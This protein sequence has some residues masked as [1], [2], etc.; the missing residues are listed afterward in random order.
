MAV[1]RRDHELGSGRISSSLPLQ[2][3]TRR[4]PGQLGGFS[5]GF[6]P[7]SCGFP[8]LLVVPVIEM[9][10]RGEE[11]QARVQTKGVGHPG[12]PAPP[13]LRGNAPLPPSPPCTRRP[14]PGALHQAP[15]TAVE[16]NYSGAQ[17]EHCRVVG[18]CAAYWAHRAGRVSRVWAG[19]PGGIL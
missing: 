18:V 5:R 15:C 8:G 4:T 19:L 16:A 11:C 10:G 6:R 9:F 7:D 14:A 1:T 13:A 12:Y 2:A 17:Q 3:S